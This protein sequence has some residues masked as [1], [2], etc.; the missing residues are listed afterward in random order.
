MASKEIVTSYP[1]ECEGKAIKGETPLRENPAAISV[2]LFKSKGEVR[3]EI[4]CAYIHNG[5]CCASNDAP[6][7]HLFPDSSD[8]PT[9]SNRSVGPREALVP[10][11]GEKLRSIRL[12]TGFT[13]EQLSRLAHVSSSYVGKLEKGNARTNPERARLI[14]DALH[15]P[16]ED[17]LQST[18]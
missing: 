17:F 13:Q 8:Y 18:N 9:V 12:D 3:R 11:D 2:T 10:V 14:A 5:R 16:I 1:L 4:G 6:C 7:I 15:R